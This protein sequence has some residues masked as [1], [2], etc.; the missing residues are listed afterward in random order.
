MQYDSIH[1][2]QKKLN[3]RTNRQVSSDSSPQPD[4][5]LRL[6]TATITPHGIRFGR[7]VY[8]CDLAVSEDWL[9]IAALFGSWRV[10]C[11]FNPNLVDYIC[12]FPEE[13]SPIIARLAAFHVAFVGSSWMEAEELMVAHSN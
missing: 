4:A 9:P 3:E 1:V 2:A 5:C 11:A 7:L 13:S 8:E 6:G 12:L 10:Q